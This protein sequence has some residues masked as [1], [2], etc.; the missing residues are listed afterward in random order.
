M[1]NISIDRY[2]LIGN[3]MDAWILG[4]LDPASGTSVLLEIAR[5]YGH[6]KK[7]TG[8]KISHSYFTPSFNLGLIYK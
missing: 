1:R 8:N 5:V 2:V 7:E 3:H 6:I 4:G